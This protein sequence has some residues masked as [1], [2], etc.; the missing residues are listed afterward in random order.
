MAVYLFFWQVFLEH[1]GTIEDLEYSLVL[2]VLTLSKFSLE[3][4]IVNNV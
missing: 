3:G 2:T 4:K 1:P